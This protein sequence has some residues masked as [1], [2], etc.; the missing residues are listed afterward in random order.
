MADYNF[1]KDGP[2]GINYR[3]SNLLRVVYKKWDK[4]KRVSINL[5]F[6]IDFTDRIF[7]WTFF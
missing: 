6:L 7:L 4:K 2:S 5:S 3:V 1:S